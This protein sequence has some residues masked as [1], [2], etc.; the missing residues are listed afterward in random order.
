MTEFNVNFPFGKNWWKDKLY[1]GGYREVAEIVDDTWML[2]AIRHF[3][4]SQKDFATFLGVKSPTVNNWIATESFPGYAKRLL[5]NTLTETYRSKGTAL[6]LKAQEEALLAERR[7]TIANEGDLFVI[8]SGFSRDKH[9]NREVLAKNVPTLKDALSFAG[10]TE[11]MNLI[12]EFCLDYNEFTLTFLEE[13]VSD[14]D[15]LD[16]D[17]EGVSVEDAADVAEQKNQYYS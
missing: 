4:R 6:E 16:Y 3:F 1:T 10:A 12:H 8:L 15:N 9:R 5:V 14:L 17:G 13:I 11:G 2:G 7:P